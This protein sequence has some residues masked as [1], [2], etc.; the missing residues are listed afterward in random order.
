MENFPVNVFY[1]SSDQFASVAAT[2]IISLM[3]NNQS[4]S[5]LHI[6]LI[7]DDITTENKNKLIQMVQK[8]K[9][10][11]HFIP[12][13]DPCKAFRYP[14]KDKYQMGHS[15][16]RMCV[17]HLLPESVDRVLCLD[18][19]TLILDDLTELWNMDMKENIL[20][21]VADCMN[22]E[23]YHRQFGLSGNEIYCNAGVFLVDLK[24][25]RDQNIE[26]NIID[27]IH[28]KK[29]NVFF[30][31]QTLMNYCCRGKIAKL[32]PKYNTYTLFYAFDY[33]NLLCWRK[34]T[35]FYQQ[36]EVSKAKE[37][38]AIIHFTRNFYM[39]SR[40]WVKG[41]DHP[42]TMDYLTYKKMTSWPS[43][44]R[45]TRTTWQRRKYKIWHLLPQRELCIIAN[46]IY[47]NIRPNM[48]WKNE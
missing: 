12:A 30:F 48:W 25:W 4:F 18:S 26:E 21:G 43:I 14:F 11:I 33:K 2:S 27:V 13:P 42:L 38:P 37:K 16:V 6:Y 34:P 36:D 22:L 5:E 23:A 10:D 47:N 24:K 3:E 7:D 17:G 44:E 29:G 45:D 19:D 46:I 39:L 31:E 28:K 40:P 1:F 32:D 41:C 9:R 20:A 35:F 15:Y 8:Y